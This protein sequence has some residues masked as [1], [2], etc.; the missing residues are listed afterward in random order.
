MAQT[1]ISDATTGFRAYSNHAARTLA[2]MSFSSGMGASSQILMEAFRSGLRIAE[3]PVNIS[4]DTGV[5]T[6]TQNAISMGLGILTSIIRY[7]TIRRPLSLIG[8]PGL[9]ILSIGVVGL[10]LILDIFNATRMIPIGLGM[11][12][13][14][15]AIIGLVILL[16]SLFL[17][18]LST[19]SKQIL[20]YTGRQ[21]MLQM[22]KWLVVQKRLP[23]YDILLSDDLYH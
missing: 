11:F 21:L 12:T 20:A 13:V 5:D 17:Y 7:I 9:A 1:T 10:F 6:S 14:A 15:T 23:L 18:S 16:G 4:Y 3:V 22:Q 19:V 8:I 2:S